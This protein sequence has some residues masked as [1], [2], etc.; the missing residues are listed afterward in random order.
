MKIAVVGGIGSGKSTVMK[1]MAAKMPDHLFFSVDEAVNA[2]YDEGE[3]LSK[4]EPLGIFTK[5]QMSDI[6]FDNPFIMK[7][8]K[9]ISEPIISRF[10]DMWL[11]TDNVIIEFPLLFN[12]P[13]YVDQFDVIIGITAATYQRIDRVCKRNNF[14][15][16]K[17]KTIIDSQRSQ[18]EILDECDIVYDT[19]DEAAISIDDLILKAN[20]V[21]KAREIDKSPTK[22]SYS[23]GIVSG[24][25]DPISNGHLWIVNKALDLV[26]HVYIVIASNAAKTPLFTDD[27]KVNMIHESI[28]EVL[29]PAKVGRVFISVL[30]KDMLL[31]S[32]AKEYNAKHIFRG[33]RSE[34][35]FNFEY[36]INLAQRKIDPTVEMIYLMPPR[37]IT[38]ISSSLVRSLY[39]IKGTDDI[40]KS[41]VPQAVFAALKKKIDETTLRN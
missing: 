40:V 20:I 30:P 2:L 41:Y 7:K 33:I 35:D 13:H 3:I 25:F 21:F 5:E 32:L 11:K 8:L 4:F 39:Q 17:V 26:D 29:P 36:Q 10:I 37:E 38:E 6:A 22:Q 23:V 31:I 19:S 16:E 9:E 28:N 1:Q 24:S 18:E 34:I 15:K 14:S 27:E 12:Y